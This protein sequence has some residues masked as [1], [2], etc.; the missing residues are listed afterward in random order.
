MTNEEQQEI[1]YFK[2][3]S[4]ILEHSAVCARKRSQGLADV[5]CDAAYNN[6]AVKP[7]VEWIG[8]HP[9]EARSCHVRNSSMGLE[10]VIIGIEKPVI[11][12]S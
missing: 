8:Y 4:L 5:S 2:C 7:R 6:G 11:S 3:E 1:G 10:V 9:E 12:S